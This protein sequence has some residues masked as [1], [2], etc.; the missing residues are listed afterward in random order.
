[1]S[2]DLGA[3]LTALE[4]HVQRVVKSMGELREANSR[5]AHE[6]ATLEGELRV[7]AGEVERLRERDQGRV[8]LEGEYRR[9]L[10]ERRQLLGQVEGILKELARIDGL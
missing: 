10:D 6:K 7:L 4:E 9:L 2:D 3:R 8:R 1:V 5:L